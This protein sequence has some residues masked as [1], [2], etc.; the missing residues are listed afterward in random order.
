MM[1]QEMVVE[2]RSFFVV[3]DS[4]VSGGHFVYDMRS[5]IRKNDRKCFVYNRGIGGNRSI[6]AQYL[7]EDDVFWA[8]PDY[9]ILTY[10]GNDMGM[11]LYDSDKEETPELLAKRQ[12][13]KNEFFTGVKKNVEMCLQN[14]VIPILQSTWAMNER[15][16]ER[17]DIQT[18]GDNKE[19]EEYMGPS[20]YKRATFLKLNRA[21][22]EWTNELREYAEKEHILFFDAF[23]KTRELMLKIDGLFRD[24]GVHYSEQGQHYLAKIMLEFLGYQVDGADFET[25]DFNDELRQIERNERNVA[26]FNW[27]MFN[28][29]V[30]PVIGE[31]KKLAEIKRIA[32]DENE[33]A[34]LTTGAQKYFRDYKNVKELREEIVK[35]TVAFCKG[36]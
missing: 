25:S 20:F 27:G 23:S 35:R 22:A 15:I 31:D 1:E 32:E 24:D 14:G 9:A 3:G 6:M 29:Y 36:E 21:L 30:G 11:W 26:F 16:V 17:T 34:W 12:K 2:N 4:I 33:P 7:L 10:G 28:P 5:F 19:K 13:R 8:K 18:L